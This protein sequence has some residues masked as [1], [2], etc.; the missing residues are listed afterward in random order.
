MMGEKRLF[1]RSWPLRGGLSVYLML[2]RRVECFSSSFSQ[3]HSIRA[4]GRPKLHAIAE[5]SMVSPGSHTNGTSLLK[6]NM[7]RSSC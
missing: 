2:A 1:S 6:R 7:P 4:S 3:C 5:Y